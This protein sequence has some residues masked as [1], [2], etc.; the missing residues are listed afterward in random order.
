MKLAICIPCYN[1][2]SYIAKTLHSL[3]LQEDRNFKV[4]VC[5]NGSTDQTAS[6][7]MSA[8]LE[9]G[10]N[11][12]IVHEGKKGTGAAADSAFR[13]AIAQG[14]DLL[15]RTDA[16]ALVDSSWTGAIR[17]HFQEH[18]HGLAAGITG[19]IAGEV[20]YRFNV[21]LRAASLLAS[22]FGLFRPSNYG[23]GLRGL[24]V[25]TNGNNLAIDSKTYLA[26]G[27]FRHTRIEELHEDRQLVNDVRAAGEKVFLVRAMK[28]QVSARRVNAWGLLNSL[29]W[30]ANHS[31][32]GEEI[33]IR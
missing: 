20:S 23:K 2:A 9:L 32:K 24:Y 25:M 17:K 7:A 21:M 15:A 11:L 8:G 12:E 19:P 22:T 18:P 6:L 30:Y 31:Y 16:D 26:A 33:D 4:F 13:A 29:K 1:E 5:D 10:L 28:V 3:S 14:Y 27:G